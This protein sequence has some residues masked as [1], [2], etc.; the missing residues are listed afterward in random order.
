MIG[1]SGK[2]GLCIGCGFIVVYLLWVICGFLL[3]ELIWVG[4][5][6]VGVIGWLVIVGEVD[7]WV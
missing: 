3:L 7:V 6:V 1:C 2:C 4:I 5:D